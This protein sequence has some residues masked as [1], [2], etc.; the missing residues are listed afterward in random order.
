[1]FYTT[2]LWK[3][4]FCLKMPFSI[5]FSMDLL[6]AVS[7]LSLVWECC[8]LTFNI[9]EYSHWLWNSRCQL[10]SFFIMKMLFHRLLVSMLAF[11]NSAIS[12]SCSFESYPLYRPLLQLL[13]WFSLSLVFVIYLAL[14]IL[15]IYFVCN[16]LNI[17]NLDWCL[18]WILENLSH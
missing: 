2:C 10:F 3:F 9:E 7:Q 11:E 14:T 16:S 5:S 13:L 17:M 4:F 8:Y 15:L 18:S 6:V 12:N 1:M